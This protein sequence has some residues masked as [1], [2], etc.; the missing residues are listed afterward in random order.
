MT[1]PF[2]SPYPLLSGSKKRLMRV[3][4]PMR[5]FEILLDGDGDCDISVMKGGD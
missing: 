5:R 1:C 3:G 4:S 2:R